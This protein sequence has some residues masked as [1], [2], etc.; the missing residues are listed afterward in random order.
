MD[1]DTLHWTV[2]MG[3]NSGYQLEAQQDIGIDAFAAEFQR[4]SEEVHT[5]TGI[6]ITGVVMPSRT[7]YSQQ[8]GCPKKGEISYTISGSCNPA[9][10]NPEPYMDALRLVIAE[11][12]KSYGQATM[13]LEVVPA[14][15]EYF[16]D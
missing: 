7:V 12:K 11:L 14:H 3:V 15:L 1:F 4:I 5:S 9:F 10:A 8:F 13:L 16:R 6:Y 2:T